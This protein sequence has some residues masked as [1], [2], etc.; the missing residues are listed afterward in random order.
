MSS[1]TF[2]REVQ[3]ARLA[4]T[5][6]L[7][8]IGLPAPPRAR[9]PLRRRPRHRVTPAR[10]AVQLLKPSRPPK[11]RRHHGLGLLARLRTR[12]LRRKDERGKVR[13]PPTRHGH[14]RT[15]T[16]PAE[17]DDAGEV[18]APETIRVPPLCRASSAMLP[19]RYQ[20][21]PLR[22]SGLAPARHTTGHL[23]K[24]VD[25]WYS[26]GHD[27]PRGRQSI[28]P[29]TQPDASRARGRSTRLG[30]DGR[31]LGARCPTGDATRRRRPPEHSLPGAAAAS[32]RPPTDTHPTPTPAMS[33]ARSRRVT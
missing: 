12:R 21:Y 19:P 8:V 24:G 18:H 32:T 4:R 1:P 33:T 17:D 7:N 25:S 5:N 29:P 20:S 31:P 22:S 9:T 26:R 10:P 6:T 13:P 30:N 28:A 15:E 27:D 16:D 23:T 14:P 11:Q 2:C 3:H